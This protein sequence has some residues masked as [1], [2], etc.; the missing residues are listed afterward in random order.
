[1]AHGNISPSLR[2]ERTPLYLLLDG[3]GASPARG[4]HR[5][6]GV[7]GRGRP[8]YRI[9]PGRAAAQRL[10]QEQLPERSGSTLLHTIGYT[11]EGVVEVGISLSEADLRS[12]WKAA[13]SCSADRP[14]GRL[15]EDS[16]AAGRLR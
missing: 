12:R 6:P 7:Q 13:T 5:D 14:D 16:I 9:R 1:M 8:Q 11:L 4:S 10:V 15:A 3:V 2:R